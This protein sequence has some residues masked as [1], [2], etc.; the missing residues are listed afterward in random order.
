MNP[1]RILAGVLAEFERPLRR[2]LQ[3]QDDMTLVHCVADGE[4]L[5]KAIQDCP[6]D[7]VVM[8]ML[9]PRLDALGVLEQLSSLRMP[10]TPR[11]LVVS[12]V[13]REALVRTILEAG[14]DYCLLKPVAMDL[15]GARIRQL[16]TGRGRTGLR[17]GVHGALA[18]AVVEYPAVQRSV[19]AT[20]E[21][22][23]AGLL[24]EIG[25]SSRINGHRF[26]VRA[27]DLVVE[28]ES[29]LSGVTK[30]LYPTV[31]KEY[32]STPSRVERSIRHA[33]VSAWTHGDE[34]MLQTLFGPGWKNRPP[35]SEFIAVM[36]D[37]IRIAG[38][39]G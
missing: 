7:V 18:T 36:A 30:I 1:I 11:I 15:L 39:G 28:N 21:E 17:S 16:V 35:N 38:R 19:P 34:D 24:A 4:A 33:I 9:L 27:I 12:P 14:A 23:V 6:V 3:D 22:R 29:L 32:G 26:L 37:R 20:N 5:F 31:A 13:G 2:Y 25:I 8:E 10:Q